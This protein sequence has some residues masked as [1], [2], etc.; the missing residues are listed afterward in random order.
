MTCNNAAAAAAGCPAAIQDPVE[1]WERHVEDS[2]ALLPVIE[3]HVTDRS[4]NQ[5]LEGSA[6]LSVVDVG[7]GAGLP[8]VVLAVAR[9]QWKVSRHCCCY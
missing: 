3:K 1:A 4:N 7:T 9:P 5:Q 2:L 8:G 6:G